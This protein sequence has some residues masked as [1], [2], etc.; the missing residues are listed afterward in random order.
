MTFPIY[1]KIKNVPN[2]QLACYKQVIDQLKCDIKRRI[3]HLPSVYR[4]ENHQVPAKWLF[5]EPRNSRATCPGRRDGSP[6]DAKTTGDPIHI[7]VYPLVI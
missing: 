1:G 3:Q 7:L 4:L 6:R 5:A 2:H